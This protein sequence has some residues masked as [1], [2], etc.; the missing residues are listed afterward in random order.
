[1]RSQSITVL[2]VL[3]LLAGCGQKGALVLPD[4]RV[5]SPVVIRSPQADSAPPAT[6]TPPRKPADEQDPPS[7]RP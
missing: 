1:M 3:A 5:S 7:P 6:P 2:A 4:S